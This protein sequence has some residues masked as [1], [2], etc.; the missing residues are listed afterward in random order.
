MRTSW[1]SILLV[2]AAGLTTACADGSWSRQEVCAVEISEHDPIPDETGRVVRHGPIITGDMLPGRAGRNINGPSLIRVPDWVPDPLGRYYLYFSSH[3]NRRYIRLAYADSLSGPW[4]IHGR[5]VLHRD[6]ISPFVRGVSSPEILVDDENREIRMYFNLYVRRNGIDGSRPG[7]YAA[8]SRDGLDF[9]VVSDRLGPTYS[10]VLRH[11]DWYYLFL[12]ANGQWV[13]RSVDGISRPQAGPRVL[14]GK[15]GRT[16]P[17]SRHLALQRRGEELRVFYT[18]K[19]DAP[20]RIL[21]GTIDLTEPWRDWRVTGQKEILR[22][23]MPYEGAELPV[24][25]SRFGP[26]KLGGENALRD[27]AIFEEDG[28]TWLLYVFAGE[29]GIALAELLF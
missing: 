28:R 22:P 20:E 4:R 10:R 24:E 14:P 25:P 21:M 1:P 18:R 13:S 26:A 29:C 3:R 12:G 16:D 5:G 15:R 23:Q 17:Y 6:R 11:G 8:T 7:T 19:R 9:D 2:L 27:P